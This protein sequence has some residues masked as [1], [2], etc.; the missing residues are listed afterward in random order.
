[1][2]ANDVNII[3]DKNVNMIFMDYDGTSITRQ[4]SAEAS[5]TGVLETLLI[6]CSFG[7]SKFSK[8]IFVNVYVA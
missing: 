4:S 6:A 7:A 1:M 5:I 3:A 2:E 8:K